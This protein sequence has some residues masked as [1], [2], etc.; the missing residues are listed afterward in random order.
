MEMWMKLKDT[1][2]LIRSQSGLINSGM[3]LTEQPERKNLTLNSGLG[4]TGGA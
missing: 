2:P 4:V 1:S 3:S